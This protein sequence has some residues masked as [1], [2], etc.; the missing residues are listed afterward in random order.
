MSG[1]EICK[2]SG[3]YPSKDPFV[4]IL[5]FLLWP[6]VS[7]GV[8]FS[9]PL[10]Y[11]SYSSQ[12]FQLLPSPHP[13]PQPHFPKLCGDHSLWGS[14]SL[15]CY[16]PLACLYCCSQYLRTGTFEEEM[17]LWRRFLDNKVLLSCGKAFECSEPGWFR[18]IF[19]DKTHRLQLGE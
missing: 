10:S 14:L 4:D 8:S 1:K 9:S 3:N 17:L 5:S 7:E 2:F 12:G 13:L 19:A 6:Y 11:H 18:I 15:A 16:Q